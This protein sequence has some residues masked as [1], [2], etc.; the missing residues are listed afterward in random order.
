VLEQRIHLVS[1]KS[2][3]NLARMLGMA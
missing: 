2:G 3:K 1:E